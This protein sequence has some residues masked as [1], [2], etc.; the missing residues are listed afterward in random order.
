[1]Q[2]TASC[3]F[4]DTCPDAP[5]STAGS[6]SSASSA[7]WGGCCG[8]CFLGAL[9]PYPSL[10]NGCLGKL[11]A[12]GNGRGSGGGKG[13]GDDAKTVR[14]CEM[15]RCRPAGPEIRGEINGGRLRTPHSSC[16]DAPTAPFAVGPIEVRSRPWLGSGL[17]SGLESGLAVS[18]ASILT[19]TQILTLTLTLTLIR[20]AR[21]RWHWSRQAAH[22]RSATWRRSPAAASCWGR[23]AP[24]WTGRRPSR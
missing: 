1:M 13:K 10:R 12:G 2:L 23:T 4:R 6:I 17:G 18:L 3:S 16:A 15:P 9:S 24:R 11:R 21:G 22:T 14:S 8:G 20:C 19:Q 7:D 5:A